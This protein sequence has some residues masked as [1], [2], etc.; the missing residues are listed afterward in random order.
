MSGRSLPVLEI[1]RLVSLFFL[2]FSF[3]FVARTV[4]TAPPMCLR[5]SHSFL[6]THSF[7][8]PSLFRTHSLQLSFP[9]P[10]GLTLLQP[11]CSLADYTHFNRDSQETDRWGRQATPRTTARPL[12][13]FAS[14]GANYLSFHSFSTSFRARAYRRLPTSA[15][16]FGLSSPISHSFS[17]LQPQANLSLIVSHS[18]FF[19][20]F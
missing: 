2:I 20:F 6:G 15:P 7:K 12:I 3:C 9:C 17:A 18:F 14:T 11:P 16:E 8:L 10:L 4:P 5:F 19:L 13:Y 1:D